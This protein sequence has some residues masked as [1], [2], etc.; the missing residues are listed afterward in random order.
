MVHTLRGDAVHA[1]QMG[2]IQCLGHQ[3]NMHGVMGAGIAKVIREAYPSA[4]AEYRAAIQD[5]RLSLGGLLVS[6]VGAERFIAH[7]AG[8]E[9]TGR[10]RRQTDYSAL[11]RSLFRLSTWSKET[12]KTVGL[13]Y[14]IG[15]GLAGGDWTVVAEM[16]SNA[17]ESI[18]VVL[19][20]LER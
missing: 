4:Y 19:Y 16:I 9:Y 10:G 18:H 13:P 3:V 20:R 11:R 7:L 12:G 2:D 17:F 14:G 1:L 5:K 15:C 8:Q 6:E